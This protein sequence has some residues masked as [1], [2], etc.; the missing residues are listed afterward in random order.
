MRT[1]LAVETDLP[2]IM[3]IEEE[4]FGKHVGIEGMAS[5]DLMRERIKLC[6]STLPGWFWVAL[7]DE[8]VCGYI[9]LQPTAQSLSHCISWNAATD[10]GTL[11]STFAAD[12]ENV[13]GVSMGVATRAP[14][15][16]FYALLQR[17]ILQT[18]RTSKSRFM[19]CSR[20][21]NLKRQ[22]ERGVLPETYWK[23]VDD[24]GIP[25]DPL[26][27]KFYSAFGVGPHTFLRDGWPADIESGGHAAL[28]VVEDLCLSLDHLAE[29]LYASGKM[30]A[31]RS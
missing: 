12:G 17:S 14:S 11:R 23:L 16:T 9:V 13:F 15:G 2:A 28:V 6:N 30:D 27:K 22:T 3:K 18:L 21:P 5:E 24:N 8:G 20:L 29:R 1:R 7:S 26:L 4:S 10:Q 19:L 31:E 25:R